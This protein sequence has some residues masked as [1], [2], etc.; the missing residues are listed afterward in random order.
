LL[1]AVAAAVG[2]LTLAACGGDDGDAAAVIDGS[3]ADTV[4]TEAVATTDAIDGTGQEPAVE[5]DGPHSC[6]KVDGE[7]VALVVADTGEVANAVPSEVAGLA[8]TFSRADGTEFT[9]VAPGCRYLV[10]TASGEE[11][12]VTVSSAADPEGIDLFDEWWNVIDSGD[13]QQVEDVGER[14][15]FDYRFDDQSTTL[16]VDIG[17]RVLFVKSQPPPG[18][19]LLAEPKLI[20]LAGV[21][22]IPPSDP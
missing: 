14:A 11:H 12:R 2:L 6:D 21:T 13:R 5:T 22:L 1:L 7:L 10:T 9:Y 15:F 8:A 3:G 16:V 20:A 17:D 18:E 4:T 19:A